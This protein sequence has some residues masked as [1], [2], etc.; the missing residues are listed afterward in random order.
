MHDG[1]IPEQGRRQKDETK[2]WVQ[3]RLKQSVEPGRKEV[4][5]RNNQ[6]GRGERENHQKAW[7]GGKGLGVKI[8]GAASEL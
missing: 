6:T 3:R 5:A 1:R 7:H 2:N 8:L 4:Q